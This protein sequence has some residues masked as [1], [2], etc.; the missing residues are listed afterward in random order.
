MNDQK[1]HIHMGIVHA[2]DPVLPISLI[3]PLAVC[4]RTHLLLLAIIGS[5]NPISGTR[6]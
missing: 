1:A 3:R 6:C 5:L 4:R 2:F